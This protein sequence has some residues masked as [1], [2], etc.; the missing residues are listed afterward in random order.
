MCSTLR[1]RPLGTAY[2]ASSIGE[3]R[4]HRHSARNDLL[5]CVNHPKIARTGLSSRH[6]IGMYIAISLRL[7]RLLYARLQAGR[8]TRILFVT[9][10]VN[11][12]LITT[13]RMV[14][15]HML[16]KA[17]TMIVVY[18]CTGERG[19]SW[20]HRSHGRSECPGHILQ[21][22]QYPNS[23]GPGFDLCGADPY[24]RRSSCMPTTLSPVSALT[25]HV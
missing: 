13:V 9:A 14:L 21:H 19:S 5:W 25:C 11:F 17:L 7:F 24:L 4:A 20:I 3:G 2:H 10:L 16:T 8:R 18:C 15:H 23:Y 1:S 6:V 12:S 22:A